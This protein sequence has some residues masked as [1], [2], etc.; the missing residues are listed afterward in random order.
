MEYENQSTMQSQV[1]INNVLPN[2]TGTENY[3]RYLSG[4]HI[5]DGVKYL[6]EAAGCFWLLDILVSAQ[7]LPKVKKEEFQVLKFNKNKM[8]VQIEDGNNNVVYKQKLQ[9]TDCPLPE[10]SIWFANKIIYLPSEH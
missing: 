9:F 2:F 5:T 6:A 4:I 1:E 7:Q 10:I 3:H 8:V